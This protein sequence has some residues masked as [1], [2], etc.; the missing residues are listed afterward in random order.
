MYSMKHDN[1]RG[2]LYA[3]PHFF[4]ALILIAACHVLGTAAPSLAEETSEETSAALRKVV[5]EGLRAY[6]AED[7]AG[8]LRGIH[9]QSPEYEP[10]KA[11][12]AGQFAE[13]DAQT[14][15]AFFYY[16]GHDD[17][18][19]VARIKLKTVSAESDFADNVTDTLAVFKQERGAWKYWTD[20]IL[21]VT[22]ED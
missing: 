16:I 11:A 22:F 19:A 21:G 3:L 4:A 13:D 6:D 5:E 15:L 10:T 18:F 9:T 1:R 8:F 2:R 17:E 7:A 12:L 14:T 20:S